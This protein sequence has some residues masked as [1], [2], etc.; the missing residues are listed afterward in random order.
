M[1]T[2]SDPRLPNRQDIKAAKAA[3][4]QLRNLYPGPG[5]AAL[6]L[7]AAEDGTEAVVTL[8]RAACDLLIDMLSQLASGHAVTVVPVHAELTTQQAADLLNVSRPFLVSLLEQG[9]IKFH[10]VGNHRRV[11]FQD[12]MQ[13]RRARMQQSQAAL[14]ELT[15]DAERLKLGY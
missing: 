2:L 4:Q 15:A 14:T 5:P 12:L 10:R 6:Q 7:R 9:K 11:R 13:Y 1:P 8:P 3:V